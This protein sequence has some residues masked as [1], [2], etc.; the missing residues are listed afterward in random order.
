MMRTKILYPRPTNHT[1]STKLLESLSIF[2]KPQ[3][4]SIAV[5]PQVVVKKRG[6]GS[7]SRYFLIG[8]SSD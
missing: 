5:W 4:L 3:A 2:S 6:A 1:T 8:G 7:C